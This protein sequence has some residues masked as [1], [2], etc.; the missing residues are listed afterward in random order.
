MPTQ[1]SE[2]S[3]ENFND[4]ESSKKSQNGRLVYEWSADNSPSA[5]NNREPLLPK[6]SK[7]VS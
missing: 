4:G 2:S 6:K 1:I 7:S 5:A 3:I